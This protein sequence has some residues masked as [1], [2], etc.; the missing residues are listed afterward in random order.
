MS[1]A[2]IAPVMN[3]SF[4]ADENQANASGNDFL[5]LI[6]Q[7][8]NSL[9]TADVNVSGFSGESVSLADMWLSGGKVMPEDGFRALFA[10]EN[11]FTLFDGIDGKKKS[12]KEICEEMAEQLSAAGWASAD[13]AALFE[14]QLGTQNAAGD[15]FPII[16]AAA[17]KIRNI[18]INSGDMQILEQQTEST[19]QYVTEADVE[20]G[21]PGIVR[22][23]ESFGNIDVS[24]QESELFPVVMPEVKLGSSEDQDVLA[25]SVYAQTPSDEMTDRPVFSV[26]E[27]FA[28]TGSS[29][30]SVSETGSSVH[31]V[32]VVESSE[33]FVQNSVSEASGA[34]GYTEPEVSAAD[35]NA[36][37]P[38]FVYMQNSVKEHQSPVHTD[39]MSIAESE[40]PGI[41]PMGLPAVRMLKSEE[42]DIL[43]SSLTD[44]TH[45]AVEVEARQTV[46]PELEAAVMS[47]NKKSGS[48]S[49]ESVKPVKN[50][51]NSVNTELHNAEITDSENAQMPGNERMN[52]FGT[53]TGEKESFSEKSADVPVKKEIKTEDS[54]DSE[55]K[56]SSLEQLQKNA[57]FISRA[58]MAGRDISS[59][60]FMKDEI[61]SQTADLMTKQM[62]M[63]KTEFTLS[64]SP[65]G[66][67]KVTVKLVKNADGLAVTMTA[68]N[69]ETAKVLNER[70]G[71]L[72]EALQFGRTDAVQVTVEKPAGDFEHFNHGSMYKPFDGFGAGKG[73]DGNHS[74]THSAD[75]V[76]NDEP[77]NADG[78]EVMMTQ[79]ESLLNAYV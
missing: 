42:I 59:E 22:D 70:L 15:L 17:G 79:P 7:L 13:I 73:R 45:S 9:Y 6:T 27:P 5:A 49:M 67:G 12:V 57:S 41:T 35:I 34:G 66:L 64:L 71:Q 61:V 54:T 1:D 53:H 19:P 25:Q 30:H 46:L 40:D 69:P 72:Q 23:A 65:E 36:A 47:Q 33:H 76:L 74:G 56:L 52:E 63:G 18:Y 68:L 50:M 24:V 11:G 43:K 60:V 20:L 78:A 28:K 32:S 2:V 58:D 31:S 75:Y 16:E 3:Q 51:G 62:G 37:N 39:E 38:D 10:D 48:E 26:R 21:N 14:N 55:S 29:V 77:A 8:T 44:E 4:A